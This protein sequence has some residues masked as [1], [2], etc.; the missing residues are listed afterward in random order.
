[1]S[2]HAHPG[3]VHGSPRAAQRL[4][5]TH[6]LLLLGWALASLGYWGPWIAHPTAALT[7]SGVDMAEF[8]KFLPGVLEGSLH[9]TRQMFYS[10]AF[11]VVASIALL[12]GSRRLGFPWTLRLPV[13]ALAIPVSLQL[14]PPAWSPT[15][16]VAAEFRFQTITLGAC[17]MLLA[18]F[19]LL[20]R[21]PPTLA[22]SLAS[23]LTLAAGALS[24]WGLWIT[25]PAIDTVY[26]IAPSVG[27]GFFL[28]MSGL[29]IAAGTGLALALQWRG[30]SRGSWPTR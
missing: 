15:S 17:W 1:L 14:L 26:G 9:I 13:L 19:C 7:L 12:L 24:I 16:L 23:A 4:G 20:G 2:I 11:A 27:W 5:I 6:S 10:P 28:C 8:V 29:A 25:K 18:G 3:R 22:G 30:R 21:L